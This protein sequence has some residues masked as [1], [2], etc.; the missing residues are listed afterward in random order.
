MSDKTAAFH[1]RK[2]LLDADFAVEMQKLE[3]RHVAER[4][5]LEAEFNELYLENSQLAGFRR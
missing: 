2:A 5:A 4:E 3:A 1:A